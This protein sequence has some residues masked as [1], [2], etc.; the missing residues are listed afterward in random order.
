MAVPIDAKLA[1]IAHLINKL[2]VDALC[3]LSC[4][5]EKLDTPVRMLH[6]F[7]MHISSLATIG[8]SYLK[9]AR[10]T[11]CHNSDVRH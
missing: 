6:F 4:D 7:C 3:V 11:P 1:T 9:A 8:R 10:F 5:G 2:M